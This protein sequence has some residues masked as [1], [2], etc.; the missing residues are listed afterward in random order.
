M[1]FSSSAPDRPSKQVRER[2]AQSPSLG[3]SIAVAA[4]L[5]LAVAMNPADSNGAFADEVPATAGTT[6][7][8][9]AA[10]EAPA[11]AP[12]AN[13][14]RPAKTPA[15]AG[16]AAAP[17]KPLLR[18]KSARNLPVRG[19][20][21][22]SAQAA[23]STDLTAPVT[24]VGF[25]EGQSFQ[26]G[27]IL[28]SFDCARQKAELNSA[29]ALQNEMAA[30]LESATTLARNGAGARL[31]LATARARTERATADA[32]AI[33]LRLKQCSIAAPF[34]GSVV[35]IAIH[36]HE[37]PVPG[38]PL[39]RIVSLKDPEI[40][41]IVPSS[42]LNWLTPGAE[43]EFFVEETQKGYPARVQRLGATADTVS[44]T[45]KVFATFSSPVPSI[46]PGSSGSAKF[47]RDES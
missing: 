1:T 12:A 26:A 3:L 27:D 31:D 43:F 20:V 10:S 34:D 5:A 11:S 16:P 25:K 33:R 46:L 41:L 37:M 29:E 2:P 21:R 18:A 35:E 4:V 13:P 38:K 30:A 24:S 22:P 45:L 39:L 17:S 28:L 44:Q 15:E 36:E 7:G 47:R 19:V 14:P 8:A 32:E 9:P 40:E 42:W 6:S 23:I